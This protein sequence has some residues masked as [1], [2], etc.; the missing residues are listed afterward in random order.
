MRPVSASL[1]ALFVAFSI[2]ATAPAQQKSPQPK[3]LIEA[4]APTSYVGGIMPMTFGSTCHATSDAKSPYLGTYKPVTI[5]DLLAEPV[6]I[7]KVTAYGTRWTSPDEIRGR[8]LQVLV[9]GADAPLPYEPW[10]EGVFPDIVA[11]IQFA[12]KK[13]GTF[14]E[15]GGHVCFTDPS[16]AV[17]W[18]RVRLEK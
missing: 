4:K 14:E 17:I 3:I 11:T 13:R 6:A 9:A 16:G 10:D 5:A 7:V 18:T 15:S 2:G 12:D 1:L 8:L